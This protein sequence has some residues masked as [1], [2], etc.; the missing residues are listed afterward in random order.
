MVD[1]SRFIPASAEA[2][3]D[4]ISS[5]MG[6]PLTIGVGE[7]KYLRFMPAFKEVD[8]RGVWFSSANRHWGVP[9]V[10][11]DSEEARSTTFDCPASVGARC[12]VCE[13]KALFQQIGA[14]DKDG[15]GGCKPSRR[16]RFN[17]IDA[18]RPQAGVL[19]FED[20][21]TTW[22]L[23][24]NMVRKDRNPLLMDPFEGS[25]LVVENTGEK[26]VWRDIYE[27]KGG[28]MSLDEMH[29]DALEWALP[30]NL[31]DL[32]AS[33]DF[34]SYDDQVAMF[35]GVDARERLFDPGSDTKALPEAEQENIKEVESE[36]VN[37]DTDDE[38]EEGEDEVRPWEQ[39]REES[40]TKEDRPKPSKSQ[41]GSSLLEKFQAEID[42]AEEESE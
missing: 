4:A 25:I 15:P 14:W 34:P 22:K 36:V 17:V 20:G 18:E 42:A 2:A 6:G 13:N 37:D 19:I 32:D 3:D 21:I 8:G 1:R 41:G 30:E 16:V 11:Q 7:K 9:L 31:P 29:P 38:E 26:G 12:I 28:K 35:T 40:E 33:W 24:R 39:A 5:F 23:L 10:R 27:A